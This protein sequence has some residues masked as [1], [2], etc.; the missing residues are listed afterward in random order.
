MAESHFHCILRDSNSST[1]V[2]WLND[3]FLLLYT[4]YKEL[5][6]PITSQLLNENEW[7]N[8]S[9]QHYYT[10]DDK[11]ITL[12]SWISKVELWKILPYINSS[13]NIYNNLDNT[14]KSLRLKS[15]VPT[16][17]DVHTR[18][19]PLVYGIKKGVTIDGRLNYTIFSSF[20]IL[21][22]PYNEEFILPYTSLHMRYT[23]K[24]FKQ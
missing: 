18:H 24:Y 11:K 4:M 19:A 23:V 21:G 8:R 16:A 22:L 10:F 13:L 3:S 14:L 5:H 9:W 2:S 12:F 17:L 1:F 15:A 6:Y 7:N 20:P